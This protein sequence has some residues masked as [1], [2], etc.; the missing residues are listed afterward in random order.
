MSVT[1]SPARWCVSNSLLTTTIG[2]LR[3]V[4]MVVR[5]PHRD[6]ALLGSGRAA[7]PH[8]EQE[9]VE[10]GRVAVERVEVRDQ[11]HGRLRTTGGDQ[12]VHLQPGQRIDDGRSPRT[13]RPAGLA[14]DVERRLV[15]RVVQVA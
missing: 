11:T 13:E 1:G 14:E 2:V 4:R 5:T 7:L 12:P 3:S 15:A 10:H 9:P 8:R 6:R